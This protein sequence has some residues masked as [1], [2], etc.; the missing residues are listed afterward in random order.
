MMMEKV[1]A[2]YE[3]NRRMGHT[4]LMMNGL[5]G[6]KGVIVIA[7]TRVAGDWLLKVAGA[8]GVVIEVDELEKLDDYSEMPL[9]IDNGA[10][11][12]E[13]FL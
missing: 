11:S 2:Y 4:R 10:F 12:A 13:V 6:A 1:R 5:R 3:R 7:R 9:V 8:T